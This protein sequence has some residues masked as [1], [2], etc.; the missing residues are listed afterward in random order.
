MEKRLQINNRFVDWIIS[1]AEKQFAD[2]VSM[3]LIYGSHINGTANSSSD[4]DCYYIP[5]TDRGWEF[6][7]DC[8]IDGVGYDV[9]GMSWQRVERI[10][11]LEET[12]LPLVGDVKI[13]YCSSHEDM[14]KFEA[15]QTKMKNNLADRDYSFAA[16]ARRCEKSAEMCALMSHSNDMCNVRKYAGSAIMSLADAVAVFN[17]DYY[18]FGL[19]K[20]FE[21]LSHRF[22][23]VPKDI[24]GEYK[25][26][27]EAN[28]IEEI[29]AHT[30]KMHGSVCSYLNVSDVL[31][32]VSEKPAP[33]PEKINASWLAELYEEIRSTFNKIYVC[34]KDKNYIL[35]FI[36]AVCLQRDLDSNMEDGCPKYDVLSSFNFKK[37]DE[38]A[39]TVHKTENDF[40]S[41]IE[42][43]GGHI[44]RYGSFE[45]FEAAKL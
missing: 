11:N 28:S 15:L 24:V 1:R 5:K 19:K 23:N 17:N 40:V 35:A 36:S 10:A 4:V 29:K 37:L 2:D 12:L 31:P 26:I 16:A 9:F 18:H 6:G 43:N 32:A 41:F 13:L 27:I 7:V 34:C 45:D 30:L 44:K 39:E 21:D 33:V 20:Q 22:G 42:Q 25:N 14:Q 3:V 8:I 38:F